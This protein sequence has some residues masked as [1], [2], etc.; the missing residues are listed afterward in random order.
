MMRFRSNNRIRYMQD[1]SMHAG[2]PSGIDFAVA[3]ATS[4]IGGGYRLTI[5]GCRYCTLTVWNADLRHS[6]RERFRQAA[7]TE[8]KARE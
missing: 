8:P 3:K 1:H 5:R 6:V 4:L 2:I 7:E